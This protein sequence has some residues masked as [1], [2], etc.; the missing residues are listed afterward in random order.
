MSVSI[1]LGTARIVVHM[2]VNYIHTDSS[3]GSVFADSIRLIAR[4][5]AFSES[6]TMNVRCLVPVYLV[7]YPQSRRNRQSEG[8][9]HERNS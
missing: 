1:S 8:H 2:Q 3:S 9:D 4:Q 6:L 5:E 7:A